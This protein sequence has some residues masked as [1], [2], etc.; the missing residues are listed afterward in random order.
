M[1]LPNRDP[2]KPDWTT[3]RREGA[4]WRITLTLAESG[5]TVDH[6]LIAD[7]DCLTLQD[8][9]DIFHDD[10]AFLADAIGEPHYINLDML[11]RGATDLGLIYTIT[12]YDER[13]TRQP[14]DAQGRPAPRGQRA[15][16]SGV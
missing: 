15:S 7:N 2:S 12:Q 11:L 1:N 6:Y 5:E 13:T 4:L 14:P 8:L 3:L 10:E 9:L 16:A